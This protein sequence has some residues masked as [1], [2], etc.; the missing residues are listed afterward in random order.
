MVSEADT[1]DKS[2]ASVRSAAVNAFQ[3]SSFEACSTCRIAAAGAARR[4]SASA[5]APCCRRGE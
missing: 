1:R 2:L 5:S 3:L 4:K